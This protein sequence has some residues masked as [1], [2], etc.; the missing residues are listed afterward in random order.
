MGKYSLLFAELH[1][2]LRS[3]LLG[4]LKDYVSLCILQVMPKREK[5][6][7]QGIQ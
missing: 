3:K 7:T 4:T 6:F 5:W 1:G 2:Y